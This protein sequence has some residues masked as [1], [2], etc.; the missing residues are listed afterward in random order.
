VTGAPDV[1]HLRERVK[2]VR[3]LRAELEDALEP[4]ALS[5]DGRTF[6][7]EAPLRGERLPIGGYVHIEAG[8]QTLLGQVLERRVAERA[9][10]ELAVAV[11]RD[12][13]GLG[14]TSE[15]DMRVAQRLTVRFVA[16]QGLI[17]G[18]LEGD[19]FF[20]VDAEAPFADAPVALAT[21]EEAG[22]YIAAVERGLAF[23]PAVYGPAD[24]PVRLHA[25]ALNRHTFLCGQSGS[26]K[27]YSLGVLLEQL[28]L[29]TR[30][31][32][33]LLDP[34]SDYVAL[35]ELRDGAESDPR[36]TRFREVA[37]RVRVL[38]PASVG[39]GEVLQLRAAD[40]EPEA[41][42]A[43]AGLDP[44]ADRS[45]YAAFREAVDALRA[46]AASFD[47]LRQ[48]LPAELQLRLD[49][50]GIVTWEVWRGERGG[51]VLDDVLDEQDWQ[52]LVLDLGA[53][54]SPAEQRVVAERLLERLWRD[55]LGR[56]PTL[57]VIDEAHNVCPAEPEDGLQAMITD[58]CVQIAG[59]GRKYGLYLL[60]STQR[61]AKLH[62]NVLSQCE[63]IV[64]MRM[65]SRADL[66]H[67]QE[68]FSMVPGGLL[69]EASAF[70]LGESLLAGRI[71]AYPTLA[72]S[73][74]RLS[75]EGGGDVPPTW[76]QRLDA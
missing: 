6:T 51:P 8:E 46:G 37:E 5:V 49:N 12:E 33:V 10:P 22:R 58:R 31:R 42:A 11:G 71:V 36:S 29:E 34:N 74:R 25:Q 72:R 38:R 20:R 45:E 18:R 54:A 15:S 75:R 4:T 28:L 23:G 14:P 62:P 39:H 70:E 69:A 48:H 13:L 52:C 35:P 47:E 73:G 65:N 24:V 17:L 41:Q 60:A 55:R 3:G 30:L 21:E 57:I 16:A 68:V 1:A 63:N 9:G 2:R 26:G 59:E 43:L 66:A 76:A 61:P 53:L 44:L 64:L 27:T 19:T 56:R 50:L 40:L 67:L 32:I 7:V